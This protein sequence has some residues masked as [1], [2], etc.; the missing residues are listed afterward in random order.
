MILL[1]G[2]TTLMAGI[3]LILR[4]LHIWRKQIDVGVEPDVRRFLG[5]QLRRRTLTSTCI[6]VLGFTIALLHFRD[7]W[8]GRPGAPII[9]VSCAL[10]LTF[11]IFVLAVLDFAASTSALRTE[12][13]KSREAA[14]ELAR[15]YLRQRAKLKPGSGDPPARTD[16]GKEP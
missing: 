1:V 16:S 14:E 11:M 15:E 3:V 7:F 10:T 12:K 5:R 8:Q 9:L 4:H 6:A 13:G 2:V